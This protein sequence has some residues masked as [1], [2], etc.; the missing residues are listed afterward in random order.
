MVTYHSAKVT[1]G[2]IVIRDLDLPDGTEVQV[3]IERGIPELRLSR[4]DDA[5]MEEALRDSARGNWITGE[6][7]LAQLQRTMDAARTRAR[8]AGDRASRAVVG[9]KP[10][11][12][13]AKSARGR[14]R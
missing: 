10:R 6:E 14:A 8:T 5:A 3:A 11:P 12:S 2:Q 4:T 7:S 13:R 9:G 1:R